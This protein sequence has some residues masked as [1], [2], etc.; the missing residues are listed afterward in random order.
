V[1]VCVSVYLY[2]TTISKKKK[3]HA[4]QPGAT[5]MAAGQ[6]SVP[7]TGVGGMLLSHALPSH[8]QDL[9]SH[10]WELRNVPDRHH[11]EVNK[12]VVTPSF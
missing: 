6:S 7:G 4:G 3:Q 11:L 2:I 1:F 12:G 5:E 10:L 8:R 9:L